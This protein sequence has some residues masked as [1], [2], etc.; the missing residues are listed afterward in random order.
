MASELE[1]WRGPVVQDVKASMLPLPTVSQ[2]SAGPHGIVFTIVAVDIVTH[3]HMYIQR[4]VYIW[5]DVYV[6]M[7]ACTHVLCMHVC[8]EMGQEAVHC[9]PWT[10][11]S[12][13]AW[14]ALLRESLAPPPA[15]PVPAPPPTALHANQ[16]K[17]LAVGGLEA[18]GGVYLEIA[19]DYEVYQT[20]VSVHQSPYIDYCQLDFQVGFRV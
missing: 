6:C 3:T 2:K 14:L 4:D 18:A 5:M 7:H 19:V 9:Q 11:G 15:E 1:R 16:R 17:V 8:I 13:A 12:Q 10:S 20:M